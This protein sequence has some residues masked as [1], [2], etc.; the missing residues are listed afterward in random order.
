MD[1][2]RKWLDQASMWCF[3]NQYLVASIMCFL[4]AGALALV[5]L[6]INFG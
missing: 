6:T 3:I 4:I 2:L 5:I 1:R